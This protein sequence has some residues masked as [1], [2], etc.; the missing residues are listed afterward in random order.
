MTIPDYETM[1]YNMQEL[2]RYIT[3]LKDVVVY[4][5]EVTTADLNSEDSNN[6]NSNLQTKLNG[7]AEVAYQQIATYKN[8]PLPNISLQ[9]LRELMKDTNPP[10]RGR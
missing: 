6:K 2:K 9:R 8:Q 10:K 1:A 7:L 4:Y 3:E 5:R